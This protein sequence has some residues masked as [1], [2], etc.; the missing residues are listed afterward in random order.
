ME[1]QYFADNMVIYVEKQIAKKSSY[2]SI[3]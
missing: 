2:D 1:N 3:I